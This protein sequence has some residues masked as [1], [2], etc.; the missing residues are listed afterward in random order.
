MIM[1][2]PAQWLNIPTSECNSFREVTLVARN[3]WRSDYVLTISDFTAAAHISYH[4]A[5]PDQLACGAAYC[6]A[7][8]GGIISENGQLKE[9]E[10]APFNDS[11][12]PVPQMSS[13]ATISMVKPLV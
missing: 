4:K 3:R 11:H 7:E 13:K 9:W 12:P 8:N 2:K 5:L 6:V 10:M 1:S